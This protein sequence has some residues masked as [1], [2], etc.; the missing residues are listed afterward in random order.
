MKKMGLTYDT[1]M[2][3]TKVESS[4]GTSCRV[5]PRLPWCLEPKN[6]GFEL[7]TFQVASH[8]PLLRL[9]CT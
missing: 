2:T 6:L 5:P 8:K 3:K 7:K 1:H 9:W 4:Y